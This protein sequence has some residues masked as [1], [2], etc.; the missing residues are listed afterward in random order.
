MP[1]HIT[2]DIGNGFRERMPHKKIV[3]KE[4]LGEGKMKLQLR[5]V[6]LRSIDQIQSLSSVLMLKVGHNNLALSFLAAKEK[7]EVKYQ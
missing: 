4:N 2:N 1:Y 6:Q 7:R 3:E 5:S